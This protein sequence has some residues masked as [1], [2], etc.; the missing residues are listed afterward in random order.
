MIRA[1]APLNTERRKH[2]FPIFRSTLMEITN[3]KFHARTT[4]TIKGRRTTRVFAPERIANRGGYLPGSMVLLLAPGES[5]SS[6]ESRQQPRW[7]VGRCR[8]GL[9]PGGWKNEPVTRAGP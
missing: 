3:N 6:H 4:E 2:G 1:W 7:R 9:E 5:R 8:W